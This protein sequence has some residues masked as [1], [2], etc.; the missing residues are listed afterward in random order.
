MQDNM[1]IKIRTNFFPPLDKQ[2][3]YFVSILYDK[4]ISWDFSMRTL[5]GVFHKTREEAEAITNNILT[6][7]EGLCGVYMFEIAESKAKL[8]EQQAKD[9]GL[10]MWCLIEE[11]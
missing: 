9:E 11:V 6:D 2:K 4:Y 10:S 5:M 8:V 3:M 1:A 7:G